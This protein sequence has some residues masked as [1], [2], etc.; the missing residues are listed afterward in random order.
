MITISTLARA[1]QILMNC[2]RARLSF[3]IDTHMHGL[4]FGLASHAYLRSAR[5]PSAPLPRLLETRLR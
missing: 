3:A 2:R 5:A 4:Q 1:R